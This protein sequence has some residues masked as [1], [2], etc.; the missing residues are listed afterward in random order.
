MILGAIEE[1]NQTICKTSRHKEDLGFIRDMHRLL[2]YKGYIFPEVKPEDASVLNPSDNLKS[3]EEVQREE[4]L[5]QSAKLQ[6]LVRRGRPQDLKEANK[7]MKIMAGFKDDTIVESKARVAEDLDRLKRK[8]D[9]FSEMLQQSTNSGQFDPNDET[10]V[11]LFSALKVA[12]P[13]I[14]KIITE[15]QDDPDAVQNLLKLNDSVNLLVDKFNLLK[16]GDLANASKIK[17]ASNG[18]G[19]QQSLNLIDFDDDDS[20][21]ATPPPQQ[22][23]GTVDDLL[24][25]LNSLSFNNPPQANYGLGG[26]ISLGATSPP[27][28]SLSPQQSSGPNYD[29][30]AQLSQPSTS[31]A[32][33]I[34]SAPSFDLL[35][36]F[37]QPPQQQ[38]KQQQPQPPQASFKQR[39]VVNE[40]QHLK[41]EIDV[42]KHSDNFISVKAFFTNLGATPLT[43]FQFLIAVPKSLTLTLDPQVGSFIPSFGKDSVT[44]TFKIASQQGSIPS[45]K[46]KWK[47]NYS[48]NGSPIEET[49]TYAITV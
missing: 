7:L 34:A 19:V 12:Q 21:T 8:A 25:D 5:A 17:V 41:F 35:S 40:S 3:I 23:G 6:E 26:D 32:S 13:K 38:Q 46:I 20:A 47:V 1:W 10:L 33:G 14:Q 22:Q 30:F 31:S 45:W 49:A 28:Q 36:G 11:E 15:E 42:S 29:I 18:S 2:T 9:V 24:G 39:T 48:I 27:P 43:N 16:A 37:S 44:Q 4:Q